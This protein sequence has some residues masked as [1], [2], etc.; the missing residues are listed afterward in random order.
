MLY[1]H[2]ET[3]FFFSLFFG[4]NYQ[5]NSMQGSRA[6]AHK[7]HVIITI[8]MYHCCQFKYE[9]MKIKSDQEVAQSH[10]YSQ[11]S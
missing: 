1:T 10:Q 2:Q 4:I 11:Q 3:T 7:F 8:T 6:S 9:E 5:N